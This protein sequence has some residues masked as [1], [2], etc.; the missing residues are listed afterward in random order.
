R[1]RRDRQ[2]PCRRRAAPDARR[3]PGGRRVS[4]ARRR[5]RQKLSEAAQRCDG[6]KLAASAAARRGRTADLQAI[7]PPPDPSERRGD[8]AQPARPLGTAPR[9]RTHRRAALAGDCRASC[10]TPRRCGACAMIRF[11]SLLWL[12]LVAVTGFT[13]FKVKYAVQDIEE[14]LNKVRRQTVAEQQEI[15]VLRAEWTALNQPERLADLNRRFLSLAAL[16]PKQL[17]RKIED[18]P[19]RLVP[20]PAEP[21]IAAAPAPVP[22]PVAVSTETQP[23]TAMAAPVSAASQAPA[24]TVVGASAAVVTA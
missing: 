21:V 24:D 1:T 22:P 5:A 10:R 14:A 17:Q 2:R 9:R 19:L 23:E 6:R 20:E 8:R 4:L 18:I 13:T 11:T 16:G 7:D 12:T 3:P 15:H